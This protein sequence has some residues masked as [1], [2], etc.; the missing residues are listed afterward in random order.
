MSEDQEDAWAVC[1]D[2]RRIYKGKSRHEC[3]T[4]HTPDAITD[5]MKR[6]GYHCDAC[7]QAE[8]GCGY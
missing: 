1:S 8:E 5:E 3:P 7:T 4:C 2:Q 6:R